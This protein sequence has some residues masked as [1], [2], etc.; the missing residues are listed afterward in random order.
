MTVRNVLR[1]NLP[2]YSLCLLLSSPG[3]VSAAHLTAEQS[4]PI[5][6]INTF[7][8]LPQPGD[9][10]D[11]G[12][13]T[14]TIDQ[15]FQAGDY[16]SPSGSV[17]L[18][19]EFIVAAG[20]T[21]TVNGDWDASH[22]DT[23]NQLKQGA[24]IAFDGAQGVSRKYKAASDYYRAP[25][26]VVESTAQD[27][28]FFGLKAGSS[29]TFA[30]DKQGFLGSNISGGNVHLN[31][32]STGYTHHGYDRTHTR[33]CKM[34]NVLMT[35]S[36]KFE[37]FFA[38]TDNS[39][40]QCDFSNLTILSPTASLAFKSHGDAT[41]TLQGPGFSLDG[42]SVDG[43]VHYYYRPEFSLN[44]WVVRNLTATSP[45]IGWQDADSWLL[46]NAHAIPAAAANISNVYFRSERYN[47]FGF[48]FN[49]AGH[50]KRTIDSVI[51]EL[52]NLDNSESGDLYLFSA[53]G[54][55]NET[56]RIS[57]NV[58]L[59]NLNG[60]Q[61]NT[62][63][64]V[65]TANQNG[66]QIS[67]ENNVAFI[68]WHNQA[69]AVDEAA[70]TPSGTISGIKNNLFW[71]DAD[72]PGYVINTYVPNHSDILAID[73]YQNNGVY[74]ARSDGTFA[75]LNLPLSYTPNQP[76]A[77]VTPNFVD[78]QRRLETYGANVLSLDG[79]ANSAFLSFV[80]RNLSA[81][82]LN[83]LATLNNHQAYTDNHKGKLVIKDL[84]D[85][86]KQGF[87]SGQ[88]VYADNQIGL[89][90]AQP[91]EIVDDKGCPYQ[92]RHL[93]AKQTGPISDINTFG[94]TVNNGDILDAD[95]FVVTIDKDY[96]AGQISSPES[97]TVLSGAFVVEQDVTLTVNGD[98][99][100]SKP[101][102]QT[103]LK[104]GGRIEFDGLR[105]VKRH[106][107]PTKD[108]YQPPSVIVQSTPQNKAF[109]GLKVGS[110]A[111][112]DY[113][114]QDYYGANISGGNVHLNGF[115]GGY[116]HNGFDRINTKDCNMPNVLMTNSGKFELRYQA[117]ANGTCDFS[118][119]TILSPTA[120]TAFK[121]AGSL[122][123]TTVGAAY[124]LSG[125]SVDGRVEYYYRS[126]F[127]MNDWV[128]RDF[129][130]VA[131]NI[132][133]QDIDGW[134]LFHADS[135]PVGA[136][137]TSN[138][139]FRA[140][141][142]NPHGFGF[143]AAYT[144]YTSRNVDSVV[145]DFNNLDDSESGDMF[146]FGGP[147]NFNE[148]INIS[149]SI[150]LKNLNGKQSSTFLTFNSANQNGR[151][152][153][154][155]N[156]VAYIAKG[157]RAIALN[158][159]GLTPSN[160][161][162][163]VKDTIF[164]GDSDN[165]GFVI[166][167]L[168]SNSQSD[169]LANGAYGNNA[170][171]NARTDGNHVELN[172]PLSYS[173]NP[174]VSTDNPRFNDNSRRLETYAEQVLNLSR[175][176]EAAFKAHLTR[177]LSAKDINQLSQM[178]NHQSYSDNHKGQL[179]IKDMIDWIKQ[180]YI[181]TT[182]SYHHSSTT[183]G[184]LGLTAAPTFAM[185]DSDGDSVDDRFDSCAAT[186]QGELID[187]NGCAQSQ[188]DNDNDGIANA[189]DICI[190]TPAQTNVNA[191]GCSAGE[192][193]G[194]IQG[195]KHWGI[196]GGGAMAGYS[197]NPFNDKIR[198]VGTDMGT[199]FRSID[200][201]INWAP[202]RHS[203]TNYHY[204]LG[205]AAPFGFAGEKVVLH[206]P[207]GLNPVRSINAGQTFEP[208]QS[209]ALVDG[210]ERVSGWYSDTQ[211]VGTLYAMT[212]LGLWR[213]ADSG[214]NWTFVYNG[215]EIKGMFIDNNANG[216]V[217]IATED[218]I[219]SAA[220][221]INFTVY[222]T[223]GTHKIHRFSGGSDQDGRTLTYASDQTQDAID[224]SI[225]AGL[226]AGDVKA[227]YNKPNNTG[228]EVAA[229][230]VYVKRNDVEGFVVTE[231]FMGSH[232]YMAQNDPQT[233]Y[234]TGSRG[235]GRDKGTSI[236]VSKDAGATWQ[237]NL[238][239]YDWDSGYVAWDGAKMEHSPVGLNVGWYDGGYYTAGIN[240]LN[241]AQFGGSGNFFLY[242]TENSGDNWLDLTNEYKDINP[243][244]PNKGDSWATGG[245]NVTT[246]YDVKVNPANSNHIYAGYA[247]IHG[248]RS[249]DGGA[250]WKILPST[251]NSIYDFAFD[252]QDAD[253]LYKVNGSHHDFPLRE[254]S[255]NGAGGVF[256]STD[257]GDSWQRLTPD[258]SEYNRQYLSIA[259]D[260]SRNHIYA[261]SHSNG[262]IRSTDGGTTWQ[263]FN[264]GLPTALLN[265]TYPLDVVVPQIEILPNGNVYALV[266]GIRPELTQAQISD[267]G[268]QPSAVIVD[269]S[270]STT[271]Y[272]SWVNKALTGIYLLDVANG[273]TQ[274]QLL[275]GNINTASHDSWN[276]NHQPWNRPVSF[277]IDPNNTNV[278]WLSDI[279]DRTHQSQAA[280]VWKSTDNGQNWHY[281]LRH[282]MPMDIAIHPQDS[283]Y[284]IVT[285]HKMGDIGGI[286]VSKDGG[287]SWNKD[288]RPPLQDN[289]NA[290][291]FDGANFEKVI[292]G[293]FGGGMLQGDKP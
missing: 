207:Q 139:Y 254:L 223:P 146:L 250:T 48:T 64:T 35:N 133:W 228:T 49:G 155:H 51:F 244:N 261:G 138:V 141:K 128:L 24:V 246:A 99:D 190:E 19:G 43:V 14:V 197:I 169:I 196:G 266:T 150:G 209:F 57:N 174:L 147:G 16:S 191:Q 117:G 114:N 97:T 126:E 204:N 166:D 257:K 251:R 208:T 202:I 285:G 7:G 73:G 159:A 53:P 140:E 282:P 108:F 98:F 231:Q 33:E 157:N 94:V 247:D 27:K 212:N 39:L 62:F 31:G 273:A 283:N 80:T 293:F 122:N 32:F 221:G 160:T 241:S 38:M 222:H 107:I 181:P 194:E 93:T 186:P 96:I 259:F 37:L 198:F 69:I 102:V 106:Y 11:A 271:K 149:N 233:I 242:G 192:I 4:G 265:G 263:S 21:L 215:G 165:K 86:V 227:D 213:S 156:S 232:L 161:L 61:S 137:N 164:W 148:T 134:L 71:G 3:M 278:L 162:T 28:A 29:A 75:E 44:D 205:Y 105:G 277:A 47:P 274:W 143:A 68:P 45:N 289:A 280:G 183:N 238:L 116:F 17:A 41:T 136:K 286:F 119:L 284:I 234:A 104:T 82:D 188:L 236:Y 216:T 270:G 123:D 118:N 264:T 5:S 291:S 219:L 260:K 287:Q 182:T 132:G 158:E 67:L 177:H 237:L 46:Y 151:K 77:T 110:D 100:A 179:V 152:V 279:G 50:A 84:V 81:N 2:L 25:S 63:V 70:S 72:K 230:M 269:N 288:T 92:P 20:V 167:S 13:H 163:S 58:A 83:V 245:L 42:L 211:N 170:A 154:L 187:D 112:F 195:F 239:Q 168:M 124:D 59:K 144:G 268:I 258:N 60:K 1:P 173:P 9:T 214:N 275:R 76:I 101:G 95:E 40:E 171:Y 180:G 267:L 113:L 217:Y 145:F 6:D 135:I 185:N 34:P 235:W 26:L 189:Y 30:Y 103:I 172:L 229:A 176:E 178:A 225:E 55:A 252:P 111:T 290:V 115:A 218:H 127:N 184:R 131:P 90:H 193:N 120:A 8:V 36:G 224:K 262:V 79:T 201:G 292:Y 52:N 248:L 85:W 15:N 210:V 142:Y 272:Y 240:Q 253:T 220:D 199:A 18:S 109:F 256:K 54:V 125:L 281:Q 129:A 276:P 65:N 175:S 78:E 121:S 243:S 130:A 200:G 203:E 153:N 255:V 23:Q 12:S 74:N 10:L 91:G 22:I 87:V 226:L 88:S 89:C 66:R 206:A 249:L 56:V